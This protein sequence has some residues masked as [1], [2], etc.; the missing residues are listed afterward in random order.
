MTDLGVAV[1]DDPHNERALT[2]EPL[3][4]GEPI[5]AVAAVDEST[6]A[7]AIERIVVEY[8]PLPF[9]IDP[10]VSLQARRPQRAHRRQRL[11]AKA[12]RQ[13]RQPVRAGRRRRA[14]MDRGRLRRGRRGPDAAWHADPRVE[15]RR[16][17]CRVCQPP[18]S[19]STKPSRRP[20][21]AIRRSSRG[22][23]WPT[24]R[25]ASSTCTARRR[26]RRRPF[27]R[28]PSSSASIRPTSS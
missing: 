24:G 2:N 13:R 14:E 18:R 9:V 19:C 5:L 23:R 4:E 28:W 17:R 10:L 15:V 27:R 26:A 6:A 3:Y 7:E 16:R 8:E 25:T 1:A 11:A 21:S 20:T 12:R 22:R